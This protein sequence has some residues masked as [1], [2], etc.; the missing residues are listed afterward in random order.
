[1]NDMGLPK[2]Q[3]E[4]EGRRGSFGKNEFKSIVGPCDDSLASIGDND[5]D[6]VSLSLGI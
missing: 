5:E 4:E 1:M 3:A 2:E 6:G